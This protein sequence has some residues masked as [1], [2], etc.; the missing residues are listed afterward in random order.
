M[1]YFQDNWESMHNTKNECF[2]YIDDLEDYLNNLIKNYDNEKIILEKEKN[3]QI[4]ITK[5]LQE[6]NPEEEFLL[7]L[8]NKPG[9]LQKDIYKN[10]DSDIKDIFKPLPRTL[11][12]EEKIIRIKKGNSYQLFIK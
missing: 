6:H 12:K 1:I 4:K 2:S 9:I 3:K 7:L 11:E 5:Y 8:K 10:F